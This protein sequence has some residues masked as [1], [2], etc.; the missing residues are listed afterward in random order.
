MCRDIAYQVIRFEDGEI[1]GDE[2]VTFLRASLGEDVF[3]EGERFELIDGVP[4]AMAAPTLAH[5]DIAGDIFVQL[6]KAGRR[7]AH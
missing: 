2:L 5:Q 4:Y 1:S 7:Q 3:A 6:K